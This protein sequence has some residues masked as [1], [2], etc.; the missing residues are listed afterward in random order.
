MFRHVKWMVIG[1]L[2]GMTICLAVGFLIGS[3]IAGELW[4]PLENVE[5]RAFLALACQLFVK[6]TFFKIENHSVNH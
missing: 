3:F 4:S 2:T 6:R 1:Y 5:R